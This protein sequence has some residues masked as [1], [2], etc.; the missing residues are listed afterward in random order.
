MLKIISL[1]SVW[2]LLGALVGCGTP[3]ASGVREIKVEGTEFA[4]SPKEVRVK[5]GEKIN[6]VFANK[7]VVEH[8]LNLEALKIHVHAL[9]GKTTRGSFTAPTQPGVYE[10]PCAIAGHKEQGMVLKLIVE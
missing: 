2:L 6:L 7:G 9:A 10:I 5:A 8:D 3:A 1:L 4:F